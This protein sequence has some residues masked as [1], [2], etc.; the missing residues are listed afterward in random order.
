MIARDYIEGQ[1]MEGKNADDYENPQIH[2]SFLNHMIKNDVG[3]YLLILQ[4]Y[5][6]K[7]HFN[8]LNLSRN[9]PSIKNILKKN[10]QPAP[11]LNLVTLTLNE[12]KLDNLEWIAFLHMPN[13]RTLEIK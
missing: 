12:Q 3:F 4:P 5:I 13:L 11:F 8:E 7:A 2:N 10:L 1:I 6:I 9:Q